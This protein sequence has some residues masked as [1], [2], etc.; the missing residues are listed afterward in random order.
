MSVD[1]PIAK[2]LPL[3][4]TLAVLTA[5]CATTKARPAGA[6]ALQ[7]LY[8]PAA[9]KTAD[10]LAAESGLRLHREALAARLSRLATGGTD[11]NAAAT[12]A[13]GVAQKEHDAAR[14]AYRE[15]RFEAALS[16]LGRGRAALTP[17]AQQK[18]DFDL[19]AALALQ[20][21][22]CLLALKREKEAAREIDW[23]QRLRGAPYPAGE[24][25]PEVERFIARQRAALDAEAPGTLSIDSKPAGAQV[26]ID[27]RS[28]GPSPL[29]VQL[30]PGLHHVRLTRVGRHPKS[31]LQRIGSGKVERIALYLEPLAPAARAR[32]LEDALARSGWVEPGAVTALLGAEARGRWL[33]TK[34][35]PPPSATLVR[36]A[37]AKAE[38][39]PLTLSCRGADDAA[40][41]RCLGLKVRAALAPAAPAS[42]ATAVAR[43]PI[44]KRWWFWA[45]VG[46]A[47]AGAATGLAVG[48]HQ[49]STDLSI[50]STK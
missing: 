15:L 28:R 46:A 10:R 39:A 20:R 21:G 8:T 9:A 11:D 17:F 18:R 31:A 36:L 43:R 40:L 14:T 37:T 34:R 44:Y 49:P 32:Q 23:A 33:L 3:L 1:R 29:T 42:S 27:G 5:G 41:A 45:L 25:S 2:P 12:R 24:L 7:L 4:L 16:Q 13:R 26:L 48:L 30:T 47:A 6:V 19:L 22:L 50:V 35:T 38:D